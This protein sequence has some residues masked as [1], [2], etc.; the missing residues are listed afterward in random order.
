MDKDDVKKMNHTFSKLFEAISDTNQDAPIVISSPLSIFAC[1]AMLAE[2]LSGTSFKELHKLFDYD[3]DEVLDKETLECF[4]KVFRNKED[5]DVQVSIGN[6]LYTNKN[7]KI[8]PEYISVVKEKYK[9]EAESVDFSDPKTIKTINDKIAQSTNDTV[10][11]AISELSPYSFAILINT[12][13]FKAEWRDKFNKEDNQELDFIKYNDEKEKCTFMIN[14][15]MMCACDFSHDKY[16]YLALSYKSPRF[17]F[18]IEMAK[19]GQLD[20]IETKHVLKIARETKEKSIE[21]YLPKFKGMFTTDLV[22]ILKDLGVKKI[23]AAS[24]EFNKIT[25][26]QMSLATIIH[27]A[28]I[29]VDEDGVEASMFTFADAVGTISSGV[30]NTKFIV[31]RPFYFHVVETVENLILFS[32]FVEMPSF[33]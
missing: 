20:E 25:D 29:Q 10:K 1:F 14:K 26:H 17:K 27:N 9:G 19:D 15:N 30:E 6:W 11:K 13:Y 16:H 33:F 32:G 22:E 31:N 7:I 3:K 21:V 4:D 18:V 23:F 2:G 5:Q 24:K 28:F 12:V 8:K